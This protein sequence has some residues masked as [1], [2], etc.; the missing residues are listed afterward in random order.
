MTTVTLTT[1]EHVIV[2][3]LVS[4]YLQRRSRELELA[5]SRGR[6]PL[7][8]QDRAELEH[9]IDSA[10]GLLQKIGTPVIPHD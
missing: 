5:Q 4:Q 10:R 2:W 7:S 1:N 8:E 6:P 9:A 3:L